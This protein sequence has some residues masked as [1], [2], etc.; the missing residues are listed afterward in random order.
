MLPNVVLSTVAS[1]ASSWGFGWEAL[2][3]IGTMLLAVATFILARSTRGLAHNTAEEVQESKRQVDASLKQVEAAQRQAAA[4]QEAL[5]AAYEQTRLAQ[6]TLNAQIR[7]V[8]IDVPGLVGVRDTI[9]YPGREKPIA[10]DAGF[11]HVDATDAE[12]LVSVPLRNAGAGVA[13][14]RGLKLTLRTAIG[15][16]SVR[17]TP[18][19]LP[20]NER[21]RVSFRAT[22][23][24]AAFAPLSETIRAHRDFSVQVGYADLA[25][26]QYTITRFDLY[27]YA[28]ARWTVRQVHL[29]EPGSDE[30]FAGS[31][32][33]E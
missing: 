33:A 24:D 12:V 25:G 18:P 22:P 31:A 26:Q 4:A 21:G 9:M 16:P 10:G 32:P 7:P 2:V 13:M 8:L 19:N 5:D 20:P 3:A 28:G 29:E 27:C 30:P 1:E 11:V 17:I 15:P 6:L 23:G 14:I